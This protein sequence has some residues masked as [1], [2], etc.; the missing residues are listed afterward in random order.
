[1]TE[2]APLKY[3]W[4]G[5][6]FTGASDTLATFA[7]AGLRALLCLGV[8]AADRLA[9]LGD[10]DA[11]GIAGAAR[12]MSGDMRPREACRSC[13]TNAA[14]PLILRPRPAA[15]ARPCGS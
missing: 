3:I 2:N 14:R 15:W 12:T 4:Y 13:T 7:S 9:A 10:M 8:P 11:V 1:M 5:D 6:D